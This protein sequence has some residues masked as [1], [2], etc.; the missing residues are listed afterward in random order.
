MAPLSNARPAS[1]EVHH[2]TLDEV[3]THVGSEAR[4]F[5]PGAQ[6]FLG[7]QL[8]AVF[9]QRFEQFTH[10]E[11]ALH[12]VAFLLVALTM[13]LLMTPAAYSRQAEPHTVTKR[14]VTLS[15][16]LLTL[17]MIPFT[18]GVCLETYLIGRMIL[19]AVMPAAVAATGM[20]LVLTGLW[21]VLPAMARRHRSATIP[22]ST[23]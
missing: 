18:A 3:A 2:Q 9:N 7:F 21:F 14:F 16:R 17:S 11:Q 8:I 5:L 4:M 10:T 22:E 12:F 6:T 19:E 13:G 15:S 20:L 23:R 1:R